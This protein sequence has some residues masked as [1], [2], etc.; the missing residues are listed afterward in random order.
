MWESFVFMNVLTYKLPMKENHSIQS[1]YFEWYHSSLRVVS[2]DKN[3]G[4]LIEWLVFDLFY[5]TNQNDTW[6]LLRT[7]PCITYIL[8]YR[9]EAAGA[10]W[11][12]SFDDRNR[13]AIA[14][15]GG[16]QALVCYLPYSIRRFC[17]IHRI[18]G[19]CFQL[20][21]VFN[22]CCLSTLQKLFPKPFCIC[23][24]WPLQMKLLNILLYE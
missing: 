6:I 18:I 10:L 1:W 21:N 20:C 5:F 8:F 7:W 22:I 13:E 9:Q 3:L 17:Y 15:A 11:N 14:A 4:C 24:V 2:K 12:L 23:C 19:L 16:V